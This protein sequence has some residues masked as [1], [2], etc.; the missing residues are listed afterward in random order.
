MNI[1]LSKIRIMNMSRFIAF[2][3]IAAAFAACTSATKTDNANPDK[4][5]MTSVDSI[6]A[7]TIVVEPELTLSELNIDD[8]EMDY[9]KEI[10][11]TAGDKSF[12]A[13]P[14]S[15]SFALAMI[16]NI[17]DSMLQNRIIKA[18]K[19]DSLPQLNKSILKDLDLLAKDTV[20]A[21]LF[22]GNSLWLSENQLIRL[23]SKR[24]TLQKYLK[25]TV[26]DI[27][28]S[29]GLTSERIAN[30][31]Y[32]A[33][34]GHISPNIAKFNNDCALMV[35]NLIYYEG[36]WKRPF[37][38]RNTHKQAFYTT[39]GEREAEMMHK[40]SLES[41]YN[42]DNFQAVMMDLKNDCSLILI[43][44]NKGLTPL[45]VLGTLRSSTLNSIIKL[46]LPQM[47]SSLDSY[48]EVAGWETY[49][50]AARI[51]EGMIG[52]FKS[53]RPYPI[54]GGYLYSPA[55]DLTGNDGKYTVATRIYG[56]PGDVITVY[57]NESYENYMLQ[58]MLSESDLGVNV[59]N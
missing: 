2:A 29:N 26:E 19:F 5:D 41:Y 50:Y 22:I 31:G 28:F 58:V 24:Q 1:N 55:L 27:D 21:K 34:D 23:D 45:D 37:N 25:A 4:T 15:A 51:A 53:N 49:P 33:T 32:D 36:K 57:R 56:T 7:D 9:F 3:F 17:S 59:R 14:L 6:A 10:T 18:L 12:T 16:A 52:T 20:D 39:N 44:P 13:S 30:W 42:A 54:Q 43:L 40:N 38:D 11:K 8:F 48:T 47:V 35:M 46:E